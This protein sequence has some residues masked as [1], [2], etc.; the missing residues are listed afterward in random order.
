MI[1]ILKFPGNVSIPDPQLRDSIPGCYQVVK[2]FA[3]IAKPI[4]S[5]LRVKASEQE[6]THL[7]IIISA[8]TASYGGKRTLGFTNHREARRATYKTFAGLDDEGSVARRPLANFA[9]DTRCNKT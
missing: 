6:Q 8:Q 3:G 5:L 9:A 7:N 4:R 2:A 1:L